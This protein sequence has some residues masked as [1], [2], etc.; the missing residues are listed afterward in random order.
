MNLIYIQYCI[1]GGRPWVKMR[2]NG[3]ENTEDDQNNLLNMYW[4]SLKDPISGVM[5][6][7]FVLSAGDHGFRSN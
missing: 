6:T 2:P 4:S 3:H 5:I 1:S 7:M